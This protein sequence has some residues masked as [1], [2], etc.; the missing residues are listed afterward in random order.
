MHQEGEEMVRR[1]GWE[2]YHGQNRLTL[3]GFQVFQD[4]LTSMVGNIITSIE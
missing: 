4:L 1:Y 3:M 2:L